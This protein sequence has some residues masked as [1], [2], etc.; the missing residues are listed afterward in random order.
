MKHSL[1]DFFVYRYYEQKDWTVVYVTKEIYSQKDQ[2]WSVD[3]VMK[4][5][6][7]H[8]TIVRKREG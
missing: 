1:N 8:S 4:M 5:L 3:M 2:L 6:P 7:T